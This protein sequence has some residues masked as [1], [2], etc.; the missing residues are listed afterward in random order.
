MTTFGALPQQQC[1]KLGYGM[2]LIDHARRSVRPN[3]HDHSRV[4]KAYGSS[5]SDFICFLSTQRIAC[6]L[7]FMPCQ[8]GNAL[9]RVST[10]LDERTRRLAILARHRLTFRVMG[11]KCLC[12]PKTHKTFFRTSATTLWD[13]EKNLSHRLLHS[14]RVF[15]VFTT[16][17]PV[18]SLNYSAA[19]AAVHRSTGRP[20]CQRAIR[21]VWWQWYWLDSDNISFLHQCRRFRPLLAVESVEVLVIVLKRY[22]RFSG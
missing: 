21:V 5:R 12:L 10:L 15:C 2:Y 22:K 4:G 20:S 17:C 9:C 1:T 3:E 7:T 14:Q 16:I 11:R 6:A 8:V 13:A 19:G 18:R